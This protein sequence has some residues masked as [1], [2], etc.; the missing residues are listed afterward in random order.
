MLSLLPSHKDFT[1]KSERR[2]EDKS[3]DDRCR[4]IP[5]SYHNWLQSYCVYWGVMPEKHPKLCRGL[6][7]H[8]NPIL[9]A[10][11]NFGEFGW[12]F[13]DESFRQKL[14]IHLSLK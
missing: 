8:L 14:S 5:R 6:F 2:G 12:Y 13:F 3:E 10:Y 7:Q 9:E 1:G 4:P 11:K